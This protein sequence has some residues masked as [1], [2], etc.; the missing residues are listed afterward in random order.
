ELHDLA[1]TP[2]GRPEPVRWQWY[3]AGGALGG[4]AAGVGVALVLGYRRAGTPVGADVRTLGATAVRRR[5]AGAAAP[6]QADD[7]ASSAA[8]KERQAS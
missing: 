7:R 2:P 4:L 5:P 6:D 3:A 1:A 8:V